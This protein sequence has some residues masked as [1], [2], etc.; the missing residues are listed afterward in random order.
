MLSKL[1]SLNPQWRKAVS[2]CVP[3]IFCWLFT[4]LGVV[5]FK[6]YGITIFCFI[7]FFLGLSATVL[8]GYKRNVRTR[9]NIVITT[10]SLLI[11]CAGLLFFA[12][13]GIICLIMAAPLGFFIALIGT[14]AGEMLLDRYNGSPLPALIGLAFFIPLLM[15]FESLAPEEDELHSVTTSVII[16]REPEKV[17][18][19]IVTFTPIEEP[20]EWLFRAGIAYPT[21]AEI[22]GTG[23]GAIRRCN[24]STGCFIEPITTWKEP[25]LLQF[26][27][28]AT[29]APLRELSPYDL[30]P[31]HL[32]G[33]F[34]S[35]KGEFR[36]TRLEGNR[37]LV[38]GT[39][40]Y[41]HK[42]R[43]AFY[44]KIWS[45]YI[46]HKIHNRVLQHIKQEAEASTK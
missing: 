11:Y 39:T 37:T 22:E 9:T 17:W 25:E 32:H 46:I 40:W 41:Y 29:P 6:Q 43:P 14:L 42:I 21:H 24:F 31:A 4:I 19:K 23:K 10:Y 12:I 18:Q 13:E 33:Y 38:E 26:S 2:L 20:N 15:S 34:V 45:N 16:D 1:Q 8:Y 35:Q 30:K 27:V 3:A 36:L 7:P 44:W 28:E 5:T